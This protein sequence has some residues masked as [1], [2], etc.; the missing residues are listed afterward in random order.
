[1]TQT[2]VQTEWLPGGREMRLLSGVHF[3]DSRGVAW[4][5]RA[6]AVID[7]ASIPRLFWRI[8]GSPFVGKFRRASVIHD[9]YCVTKER[10]HAEVHKMFLEVMEA[11]GVPGWKR[12]F[13]YWA[14]RLFGPKWEVEL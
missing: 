11:D 2:G 4:I 3:V 10:P 9:V 8:A 5:A 1:M 14:V 12:R 13:M 7:G 6:G